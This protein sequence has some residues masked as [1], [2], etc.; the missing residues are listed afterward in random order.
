VGSPIFQI[1]DEY[2]TRTAA[3]DPVGATFRG[4]PGYDHL[5]T[6]YGPDGCAARADLMRA[7]LRELSGG[8][9]DGER[10]RLAAAHLRERIE[11]ELAYH[12]T[13]EWTRRLR[14]SFGTTQNVRDSVD[15]IRRDG[16]DGWRAVIGRLTAVPAMLASWRESL[17]AGLDQRR[18]AA[19]RQALAAAVQA[20]GY[21][22]GTHDPLLRT[23]GD[24]PLRAELAAAVA[25]AHAGYA[26]TAAYLRDGYAPR[27][28]ERDGVGP[29]RHAVH[30]RL[31]LGADLDGVA[32]RDAYEWGWAELYRIEAEIAAEERA[33]AGAELEHVDGAGAYRDWLQREHDRAVESLD[34]VHFDI[35]PPL[36]RVEVVLAP[37]SGTASVYYTAP[38]E[39]LSRPGRTWWSVSGRTRFAV[40]EELTTVYHEGVPGHHL[41]NGQARV[42]RDTLSRFTRLTGVSGHSEGWALYAERLADELGWYD[43]RPGTRLGM[44]RAQAMRAVRVVVDLG[45]HLDLP[46][47]P[48]EADRYAPRWSYDVGVAVLRERGARGLHG[49]DS[50]VARYCGWPAQAIAYKLGERAWHAARDE[51]RDRLGAAFDLKR[52]HTA[53]LGVGPIGLGGLAEALRR[54]E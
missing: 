40:W 51:A 25:A 50:E 24:G 42:A 33:L 26:E 22:A 52:W 7:T 16:P 46:L 18:P 21:A 1:C 31:A 3:L 8:R 47:P 9:P 23:Y 41:Q 17:A 12:D 13:G 48:A 37:E 27:A 28:D 45:I 5:G 35:A 32:A 39:D 54:A 11:A 19:R 2:V 10:D 49:V 14:A 30:A 20:D 15:M 43:G 38:S 29:D 6:D 34:G 36:R 44:L 4:V 53:A